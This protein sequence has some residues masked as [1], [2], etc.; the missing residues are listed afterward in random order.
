VLKQIRKPL[1][2]GFRGST[3]TIVRKAIESNYK[4][5]KS[6]RSLGKDEKSPSIRPLLTPKGNKGLSLGPKKLIVKCK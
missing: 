2:K 4:K 1:K 5:L 3:L 6:K